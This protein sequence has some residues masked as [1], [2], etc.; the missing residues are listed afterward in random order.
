[1]SY[2]CIPAVCS[3]SSP[4]WPHVWPDTRFRSYADHWLAAHFC[5]SRLR[6]RSVWSLL[7]SSDSHLWH[8]NRL[9]LCGANPVAIGSLLVLGNAAV[10]LS[11]EHDI[12][13]ES[14]AQLP[15]NLWAPSKCPLCAAQTALEMP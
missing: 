2:F 1:M 6:S 7:S 15:S 4:N 8:T 10:R 5:H 11:A 12:P 9:A 13:V 14:I 3:R